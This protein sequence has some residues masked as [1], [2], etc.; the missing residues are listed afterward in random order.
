MRIEQLQYVTT[1]IELGSLR[2]AGDQLHVSQAAISEAIT[3][4]ERELGVDILERHHSGVRASEAGRRLLPDI[5]DALAALD[6]VRRVGRAGEATERRLRA[7]TVN[8]GTASLLLPAARAVTSRSPMTSIDVRSLRHGDILNALTEGAL[9]IGLVNVL[10]GDDLPPHLAQLRLMH[11]TPVAVLPAA[12]PLTRRDSVEVE[13]FRAEPFVG[14]REGYLM[15]RFAHRIFAGDLP[16]TWHT[17]DGAE[18]G[19]LMVADGMGL[20]VLPDYSV[21]DD[22]LERAGLITARPITDVDASVAVV[23]LYRRQARMPSALQDL[24]VEL[25]R[26]GATEPRS[27]ESV[28]TL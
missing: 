2:R 22:P 1:A 25:Q 19:K 26:L 16:R 28:S 11:G 14:M 12:H 15:H 7:G 27:P 6:R 4:L 9:D 24:L 23:A 21:R 8:A 5:L 17:T 3:K 18:M 10:A 13:A 20:T